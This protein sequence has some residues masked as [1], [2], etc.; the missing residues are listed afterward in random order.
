MHK[1]YI[2]EN[3][4]VRMIDAFVNKLDIEAIERV[5]PKNEETGRTARILFY[6]GE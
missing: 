5:Q 2:S 1:D 6:A 4:P 3:N